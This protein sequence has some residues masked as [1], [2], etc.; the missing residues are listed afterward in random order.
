MVAAGDP[1]R[2]GPRDF[3][4][5]IAKRGLCHELVRFTDPP[6]KPASSEAG[7]RSVHALV[8]HMTLVAGPPEDAPS[9]IIVDDVLTTGMRIVA[10]RNKTLGYAWW[11][12]EAEDLF[13]KWRDGTLFAQAN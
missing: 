13:V 12:N 2:W 7:P 8:E 6:P 3:A 5:G 4:R 11:L 9:A 1:D 10:A